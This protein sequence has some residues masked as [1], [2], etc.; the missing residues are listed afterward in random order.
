MQS[1]LLLGV[2]SE[3]TPEGA[4]ARRTLRETWMSHRLVARTDAPAPGQQVIAKFFLRARGRRVSAGLAAEVTEHAD[5]WLSQG[6]SGARGH[7]K[8]EHTILEF[9][10]AAHAHIEAHPRLAFKFVGCV[11]SSV[12]VYVDK[13]LSALRMLPARNLYWGHGQLAT[14]VHY[15]LQPLQAF[16]KQMEAEAAAGSTRRKTRPPPHK[17][18]QTTGRGGGRTSGRPARQGQGGGGGAHTHSRIDAALQR[19]H[20]H[21]EVL[22]AALPAVTAMPAVVS[23][24]LL[25]AVVAQH[26]AAR[27]T[28][29]ENHLAA[30]PLALLAVYVHAAGLRVADASVGARDRCWSHVDVLDARHAGVRLRKPK[31]S[32]LNFCA[33]SRH[34]G[35]A[36]YKAQNGYEY[37]R[38]VSLRVE[39]RRL[40]LMWRLHGDAL[41]NSPRVLSRLYTN[42]R[43]VRKSRHFCGNAWCRWPRY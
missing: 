40:A 4:Y 38:V 35:L 43:Q 30:D 39:H 1:L 16:Q 20:A 9:L 14:Q 32:D 41:C 28:V 12:F 15:E 42:G 7:T 33:D 19:L 34:A 26:V 5:V 27:T 21:A 8:Q 10:S 36:A 13:F 31:A 37:R 6:K 11:D 2:V 3:D 22:V 24:G 25:R 23:A 18:S 29:T 17:Q